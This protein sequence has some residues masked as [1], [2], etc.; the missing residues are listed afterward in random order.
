LKGVIMRKDIVMIALCG[1]I[2]IMFLAWM[3]G[4]ST[5]DQSSNQA[6]IEVFPSSS[7]ALPAPHLLLLLLLLLLSFFLA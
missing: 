3:F 6:A 4:L 1:M 5:P 2:Y 7:S